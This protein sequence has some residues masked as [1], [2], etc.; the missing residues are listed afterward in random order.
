MYKCAHALLW[1]ASL[2]QLDRPSMWVAFLRCVLARAHA[3]HSQDL[4]PLPIH[5]QQVVTRVAHRLEGVA[6]SRRCSGHAAQHSTA[7]GVIRGQAWPTY[8]FHPSRL[9]PPRCS[10]CTLSSSPCATSL[11]PAAV[12]ISFRRF[13]RSPPSC[14]ALLSSLR[15]VGIPIARYRT[16]IYIYVY[17]HIFARMHMALCRR[18]PDAPRLEAR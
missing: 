6:K 12:V 8:Q 1:V 10:A 4:H 9:Q 17:L 7:A 18:S 15:L 11:S 13:R 16:A 3:A 5:H 2:A 14:K